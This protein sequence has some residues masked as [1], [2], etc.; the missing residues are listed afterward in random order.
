MAKEDM[1]MLWKTLTV[2]SLVVALVFSA[3]LAAAQD[4]PCDPNGD[5]VLDPNDVVTLLQLLLQG[6]PLPVGGDGNCNGDIDGVVGFR[7]L[8][9]LLKILRP[10]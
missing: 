2:I 6:T 8:L 4:L 10:V 1:C 5:G 9:E 7:D 3:G